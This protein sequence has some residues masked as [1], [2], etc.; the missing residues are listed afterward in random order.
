MLTI[1]DYLKDSEYAARCIL[2]AIWNDQKRIDQLIAHI[3]DLNTVVTSE[4]SS[5]LLMQMYAEDPDDVMAGVG[6]Y[7]ENYF[8]ADKEKF[9][10]NKELVDATTLL[11]THELSI[12]QLSGSLLEHAKRGLAAAYGSPK[13]WPS[14]RM[15]GSQGIETIIMP[16]RNQ[17]A[18]IDEAIKTGAYKN[19]EI[20]NCFKKLEA[21]VDPVFGNFTK[22][23][24]SFDLVRVFGWTEYGKYYTDISGIK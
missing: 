15:V 9:H 5:A 11:T 4:Y 23:D 21:E 2:D 1:E 24:M 3:K 18:H 12:Q 14:G 8:E 10:K 22:K 6:R 7:W 17:S 16:A 19:P 20:T 13:G